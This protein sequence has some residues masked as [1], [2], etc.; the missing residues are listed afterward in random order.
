M[1]VKLYRNKNYRYNI[2]PLFLIFNEIKKILAMTPL[3][4]SRQSPSVRQ[5]ITTFKSGG[6]TDVTFPF[7]VA[8]AL[9]RLMHLDFNLNFIIVTFGGFVF[10]NINLRLVLYKILTHFDATCNLINYSLLA[11]N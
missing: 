1:Y 2:F 6:A 8:L 5:L 7:C 10:S 11:V 3:A 4:C 9:L